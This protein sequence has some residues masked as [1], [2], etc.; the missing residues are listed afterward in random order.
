MNYLAH[1]HLSG[2]EPG[3]VVGAL[4]GDFVKGPLKGE[5]A[6]D[7][8]QGIQLHRFIDNQCQ[9]D[10]SL[11]DAAN[12]LPKHYR[13]YAGILIDLSFD[14]FLSKHWQQFHSQ[15]LAKY[16][17]NVYDILAKHLPIMPPK[18]AAFCQR[19]IEYD[20]LCYYQDWRTLDRVTMS[21]GNRLRK[22]NPLRSGIAPVKQDLLGLE[23][24]FLDTY[25]SLLAASKEQARI[26]LE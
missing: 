17:S 9:H 1:F 7:V 5:Y 4:L 13:R 2:D 23:Q 14:H 11:K 12:A 10:A 20:L 8:E 16:A 21:I 26:L 15:E 19:M 6:R 25:P 18:A 22:D 3:L 24:T